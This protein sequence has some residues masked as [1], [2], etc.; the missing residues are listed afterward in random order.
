[1]MRT[2]A[3]VKVDTTAIDESFVAQEPYFMEEVER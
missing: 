1:M 3:V 2:V